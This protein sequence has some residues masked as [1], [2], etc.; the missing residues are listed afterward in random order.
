MDMLLALSDF[1][2]I[3]NFGGTVLLTIAFIDDYLKKITLMTMFYG[4]YLKKME[5]YFPLFL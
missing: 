4:N 5:K 1:F 3:L 2:Y